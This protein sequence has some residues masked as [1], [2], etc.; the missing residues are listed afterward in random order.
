[1]QAHRL[2][3]VIPESRR[4]TIEFPRAVRTGPAELIVLVSSE[5][6][7]SDTASGSGQGRLRRLAAELASEALPFRKLTA[8]ERTARLDRVM[9]AGKGLM[10][11]SEEFARS[12]E[13]EVEFE[14]R[15][16]AG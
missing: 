15:K 6:T 4:A 7:P 3:V 2:R 10:S 13:E 9:G 8:A 12:K 5:E 11:T 14:E 1:M 16:F